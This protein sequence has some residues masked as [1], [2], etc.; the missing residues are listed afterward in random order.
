M[1]GLM[2]LAALVCLL[3]GSVL[4]LLGAIG[5]LRFPDLLSRLH[6]A[7]KPQVLG[8]IL[9]LVA[10][11]LS[12][13]SSLVIGM[14]VLTWLFQMGTAPVTSHMISRA[15]VRTGQIPEEELRQGQLPPEHD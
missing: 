8:T 2:D 5:L 1:S 9:V 6:A 10:V 3:F 11:A 14:L 12:L 7:T 4:C 13:R 15:A